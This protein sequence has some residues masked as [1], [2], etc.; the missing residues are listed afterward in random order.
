MNLNQITAKG[1]V[2]VKEAEDETC[3]GKNRKTHLGD[4]KIFIKNSYD[5][6]RT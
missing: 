3:A 6:N 4:L 5:R 1:I 2:F